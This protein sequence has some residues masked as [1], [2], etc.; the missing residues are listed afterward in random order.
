MHNG[1]VVE[2]DEGIYNI[3]FKSLNILFLF[4]YSCCHE[5]PVCF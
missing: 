5:F 3:R 4:E 1:F 2:D